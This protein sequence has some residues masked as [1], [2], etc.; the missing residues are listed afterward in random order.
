[1]T[2]ELPCVRSAVRYLE[3][4]ERA[5]YPGSIEIIL[6]RYSKRGPL[7]DDQIEKALNRPISVRIPNSYNEVIRAINAGEP[8]SSRKSD[9]RTAIQKWAG[10]I[11]A[12]GQA[13]SGRRVGPPAPRGGWSI[14]GKTAGA[15]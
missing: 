10:E 11:I 6:N 14:F 12:A 8:I 1:M 9:I 7:S 15:N 5:Q 2:A 13:Q 4:L 3:Q